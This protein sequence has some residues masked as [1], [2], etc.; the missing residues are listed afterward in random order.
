MAVSNSFDA[1]RNQL[2][3]CQRIFHT[4]MAHS[5]AIADADSR[6]LNR[7]TASF[8]H[9]VFG[10]LSDGIQMHMPRNDFVSGTADAD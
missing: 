6:E 7:S 8:Q 2:T 10:C 1:V 3:A 5:D 9:A 4:V